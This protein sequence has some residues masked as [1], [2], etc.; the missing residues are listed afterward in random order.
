LWSADIA[1]PVQIVADPIQPLYLML[2][3]LKVE[4]QSVAWQRKKTLSFFW[5]PAG[6]HTLIVYGTGLLYDW[7]RII[8][9]S[10]YNFYKLLL[11]IPHKRLTLQRATKQAKGNKRGGRKNE[12]FAWLLAENNS[13][14]KVFRLVSLVKLW[15]NISK[16]QYCKKK[17][18]LCC[19]SFTKRE[20]T[21]NNNRMLCFEVLTSASAGSSMKLAMT[22][23]V[24]STVWSFTL[25]ILF[26][27]HET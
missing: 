22:N 4:L 13:Y 14:M 23:T 10:H 5:C 6:L 17:M 27:R 24:S 25:S 8:R 3:G 15:E 20:A 16:A 1:S 9:V 12:R 11:P 7:P 19:I 18:F 2:T 26:M 21:S